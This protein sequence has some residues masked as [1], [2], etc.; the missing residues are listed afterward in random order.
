[1]GDTTV[2]NLDEFGKKISVS[3]TQ[4]KMSA[5]I[6]LRTPENGNGY[7][8]DEVKRALEEAGVKMGINE[9]AIHNV[10]SE[11]KY[12]TM[13]LVAEGKPVEHGTDGKYVLY[14]SNQT[15]SKPVIKDDG[16]VDYYN[17]K[18]YELVA[19]GDKLAEYIPPTKGFFG[20]DVCGK[21]LMPKPGRPITK[22]R[23]R[24]FKVSE[25]GN[26]YYAAIDGKVE[27][28]NTD[29][30]IINVL[31]ID[32]DVDLNIGNIDFNGDVEIRGNVISGVTVR[33]K[34]NISVGGF[35]EGAVIRSGK[36]IILKNGANGKGVARIEAAGS[37][38][39]SFLEN[40]S[41]VCG[42]DIC[43]NSIL[44]CSVVANG[45][46][47]VAGKHG[48]IY[49]GDVTGVLGVETASIGNAACVPTIVR[50]GPTKQ[51][52]NDY[53]NTLAKIKDISSEIEMLNIV[54][55]KYERIRASFPE[56]FDKD[57]YAKVLQSK[58]IKNSERTKYQNENHMLFD[59]IKDG[60]AADV[61]IDKVLYPGVKIYSENNVYET[62]NALSHLKIKKIGDK[63]DAVGLDD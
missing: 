18:L 15:S 62:D 17:L 54:L 42:G 60:A 19:E 55:A 32:G 13:E 26:T 34:G 21:L 30:N 23:G 49:G 7:R 3:V 61:N 59:L 45:R 9:S 50:I 25:D 22:L 4:D 31:Q 20:Y 29:L 57:N 40:L 56:K 39:A 33:A 48:V 43:A 12:D 51:L 5:Y 35:V 28:R 63:L 37:V 53:Q 11:K 2:N 1:M 58:I 24:G 41:V 38:Q 44:N 10:L 14:F 16:S 52:R 47:I 36:D 46:V 8:Y 6:C 27:Y